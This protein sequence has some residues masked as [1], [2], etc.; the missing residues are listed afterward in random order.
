MQVTRLALGETAV[1]QQA[2]VRIIA[3][4]DQHFGWSCELLRGLLWITA[5]DRGEYRSSGAAEH[6]ALVWAEAQGAVSAI[7]EMTGAERSYDIDH[8]GRSDAMSQ[9]E[10]IAVDIPIIGDPSPIKQPPRI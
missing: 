8:S 5:R 3:Y 6:A 2:R 4:T 7:V 10:G 1:E 9:E